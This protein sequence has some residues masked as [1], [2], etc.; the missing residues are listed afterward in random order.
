MVS[1]SG[2]APSRWHTSTNPSLNLRAVATLDTSVTLFFILMSS[3]FLLYTDAN[4]VFLG[5]S[6]CLAPRAMSSFCLGVSTIVSH[7]FRIA[8]LLM[9]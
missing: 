9:I 3:V 4:R 8:L 7:C 1:F 2:T 6:F 5:D